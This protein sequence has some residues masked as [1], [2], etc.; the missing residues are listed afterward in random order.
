MN[1]T[2][3]FP[4][5]EVKRFSSKARRY[6]VRASRFASSLGRS[7]DVNFGFISEAQGARLLNA[8]MWGMLSG[9]AGGTDKVLRRRGLVEDYNGAA[10]LT[11]RGEVF[12]EILTRSAEANGWTWKGRRTVTVKTH[13]VPILLLRFCETGKRQ[14]RAR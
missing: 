12:K 7:V 10:R 1:R 11:R 4:Q 2:N 5:S 8:N 14:K 6:S 9:S 13:S 3:V